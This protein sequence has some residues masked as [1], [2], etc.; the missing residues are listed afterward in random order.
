MRT[1]FEVLSEGVRLKVRLQPNASSDRVDG[2]YGTGED[3]RIKAHV[4]TVPEK[5][6]ANKSLLKL[7]AK[8]LGCPVSQ[9]TLIK[10]QTDRNKTIL[11]TGNA[12]PVVET[13]SNWFAKE[14][15]KADN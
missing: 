8:F 11:I 4:T 12:D 10:G 3:C 5:G 1:P 14:C 6:K 7:L 15:E 2:I 13:L 9:L